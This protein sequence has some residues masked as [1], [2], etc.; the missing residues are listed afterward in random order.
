MNL[1]IYLLIFILSLMLYLLLFFSVVG[2]FSRRTP[3]G[4]V[5][6]IPILINLLTGVKAQETGGI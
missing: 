5:S 3:T 2:T 1:F 6:Y 4:T